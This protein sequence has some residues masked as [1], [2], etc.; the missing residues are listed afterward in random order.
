MYRMCSFCLWFVCDVLY[1]YTC[2]MRCFCVGCV[3]GVLKKIMYR[4]I[5]C[6]TWS[7]WCTVYVL[8]EHDASGLRLFVV[9]LWCV[10]CMYLKHMMFLCCVCLWFV[11][12]VCFVYV[13]ETHDVFV[14]RVFVVCL[15]YMC[16]LLVKHDVSVL[17]VFLV[18]LLC[19]LSVLVERGVSFCR[20]FVFVCGF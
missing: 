15:W 2:R 10:L 16:M 6:R 18:F 17:G 14:L 8:V 9:C 20:R 19:T 5:I 7:L 1:M 13:L 12:G 11:C 4:I 3:W